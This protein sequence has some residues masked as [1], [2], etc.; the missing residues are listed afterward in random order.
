MKEAVVSVVV[1]GSHASGRSVI[2]HRIQRLLIEEGF[3]N[4]S[5]TESGVPASSIATGT[6]LKNIHITLHEIETKD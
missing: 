2:L 1:K 4:V 3:T 6:Q 5:L